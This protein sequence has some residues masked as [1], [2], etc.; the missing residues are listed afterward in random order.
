MDRDAHETDNDAR[1]YMG[2][3]R[4]SFGSL[5]DVV[6][7]V[8]EATIDSTLQTLLLRPISSLELL[9]QLVRVMIE[10]LKC[11]CGAPR[12]AGTTADGR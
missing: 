7:A 10:L 11:G 12:P 4:Y 6:H 5:D 3:S 1:K 9:D 2:V 8:T